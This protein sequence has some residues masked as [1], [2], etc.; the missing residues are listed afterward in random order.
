V[1]TEILDD[2]VGFVFG[3]EV[4]MEIVDSSKML[5]TTYYTKWVSLEKKT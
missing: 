1:D 3:A 5:V 4:E 2:H